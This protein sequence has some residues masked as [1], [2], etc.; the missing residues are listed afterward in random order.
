MPSKRVAKQVATSRQSTPAWLKIENHLRSLI[1][2]GGGRSHPLPAEPELAARF[3]VARMTV[4]Q[5]YQRLVSAGVIVR[6]RGVGSF[7]TGHVFEDLPVQ[8][9]PDFSAWIR[10]GAETVR[11]VLKYGIT[12]AP[13]AV[14]KAL[15]LPPNA[16]VTHL[17]RLRLINGVPSL[18]TRYMP[19]SV[20]PNVSRKEIE[21]GSLS[22]ALISKGI[23]VASGQM[24]IDS[25]AASAAE[26]ARLGVSIGHPVLE[27]R[28]VLNDA[29]GRPILIGK[30]VNPA[31]KAYT[32]R[33][34]FRRTI[35]DANADGVEYVRDIPASRDR[36]S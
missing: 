13:P 27:R 16:K 17:Q 24:E 6:Y 33:I 15:N 35:D 32:F 31:G 18:D 5:A 22:E 29:T 10:S 36:S 3:K 1:R 14:A 12:T 8:G 23:S 19:A 30:S 25:H 26:A 4:R 2:A 9:V 7:V 21:L 20:Y 34:Q 28:I 11:R